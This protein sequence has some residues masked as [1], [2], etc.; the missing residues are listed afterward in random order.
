MFDKLEKHH[1]GIIITYEKKIILEKRGIVFQEDQI[2]GTLVAFEKDEEIGIY[3][4]YIVQSGRVA[5]VKPGFYHFCYNIP[6]AITMN[7]VEAFI[8]DKK[9]GFPITD[10]EEAGANECGWVRFYYLKNQ[11]VIELNLCENPNV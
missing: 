7:K 8:K 2:Q 4:E 10:L 11:G 1:I 9:L 5:N 6:D 3:R